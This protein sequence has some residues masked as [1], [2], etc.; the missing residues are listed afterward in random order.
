ME[1][2][3]SKIVDKPDRI[4]A[5]MFLDLKD[6]FDDDEMYPGYHVKSLIDGIVARIR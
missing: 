6:T 4:Y 5:K 3:L 2:D 1:F